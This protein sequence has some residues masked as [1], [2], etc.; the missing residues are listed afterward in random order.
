MKRLIPIYLASKSPRR[1][2]LL[3]QLEIRYETIVPNITEELNEKNPARLAVKIARDKVMSV[4]KKIKNGI[5]IGV[6]TIVVVDNSILG[7]PKNKAD[8]YKM[9][10]RLSGRAHRVISGL[11]MLR[12]PE[13]KFY[14]IAEQTVV[15][16]RR[17]SKSIIVD[18]INTRE[19]YDKAG[20]Y[21][22]QG[23]A[24]S[25]IESINGCYY[26]VVGLPITKLLDGLKKIG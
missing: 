11:Y 7:K 18:Y 5:I 17:L 16:F 6:D 22:I 19:P 20:A 12:L 13:N 14:Q 3:K 15:R 26:N 2:Q 23:K 24:G 8:A 21:G 10:K 1:Q 4:K 9:M 25:F